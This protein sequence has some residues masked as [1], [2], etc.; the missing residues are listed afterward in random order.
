MQR[1][2]NP[3]LDEQKIQVKR[4]RIYLASRDTLYSKRF[5]SFSKRFRLAVIDHSQHSKRFPKL[6]Q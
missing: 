5:E 1:S 6:Q 2:I 4:A 3:K